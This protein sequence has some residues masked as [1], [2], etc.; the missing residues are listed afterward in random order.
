MGGTIGLATFFGTYIARMISFEMRPLEKTLAKVES[1]SYKILGINVTKQMSW[2]EYF[3][4]IFLTNIVVLLFVVLVLTFQ[5]YLPFSDGKA[6]L[7]LDLAFNTAVSFITDTDI[8]HYTGDQQLS[9]FSQMIALTFTMFVAPASGIAAAFAFIRSFIRKN[10]GLGN[11]YMDFTRIVL[12]LLLPVAIVS[13][14]VLMAIGV[15]QTLDSHIKYTNLE[16]SIA[17]SNSITINNKAAHNQSMLAKS[18]SKSTQTNMT[19]GPVASFESIKLLGSNG[20]GFFG[21]NSAHPFENPT[22]LSNMYEMF[23]M[24]IIPLSFP[25]A[26]AKL[27]GK[28]RGIAILVAMLI[29]F[30]ILITI[31]L[32]VNNGPVS[33]E[34]RFGNYDSVLFNT[35]SLAT[36][37]GTANS[38]LTGMSPNAITSFFLAMFVQ[39]IPGADGTGMITM[40]VYIILTLF[41][42]GLMVGK[43][44]EFMSMKISPKDIKLA[45][46][47]FLSHPAIILIPTVMSI[48]T[49]NAQA[50][51]DHKVTPMDY[52]QTLYEYTSAAANNG[53]DY[54]GSSA[55]TP[56]W[57]WSTALV[58]FLGRFI[59]LGL[60]LA[61][62][63]SFTIKDRKETIEPIKTHGSLFISVLIIMTFLLTVLTFFPFLILGPFSL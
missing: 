11:F 56:F 33:L 52:T 15:P 36:N 25:I 5:N 53:S 6:G 42:V 16:N 2:K 46:F 14:L 30:G 34:T 59:P 23:L 38:A 60:M 3:F 47:I 40:I 55:N 12:T 13:S 8:Q 9:N 10:F 43:T 17:N 31:A 19:T 63:G 7:S 24:L 48:S 62:A 4:A 50:I 28:G 45:V 29:S 49:G 41:I 57:N 22:G 26:Y 32:S 20:G 35:V 58:M 1:I 61:I 54:F 37:T 21:S 44:P 39:A 27:M 18:T 51:T